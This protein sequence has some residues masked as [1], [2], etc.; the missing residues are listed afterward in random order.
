[1]YYAWTNAHGRPFCSTI[2]H[3]SPICLLYLGV[4][5]GLRWPWTCNGGHFLVMF[6]ENT[7]SW[8]MIIASSFLILM[9]CKRNVLMRYSFA[10]GDL[11]FK[12]E[13]S[14]QVWVYPHVLPWSGGHE[15][16]P[17]AGWPW[18]AKYF[19]LSR[20]WSHWWPS[21]YSRHLSAMKYTTMIWRSWVL[22]P[23][24]S[25]LWCVILLS[26]ST[27]IKCIHMLNTF[28]IIKNNGVHLLDTQCC[29][30]NYDCEIPINRDRMLMN[31]QKSI[32]MAWGRLR[33]WTNGQTLFMDIV[34]QSQ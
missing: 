6:N 17:H 27:W 33:P 24:G 34:F 25:N 2:L 7:I 21:G 13:Q 11:D 5:T 8:W 23:V 12:H 29:I 4:S 14:G 32:P 31:S 22:T 10:G 3:S 26:K 20:T 1:M 19:C 18:G 16:E 28:H 15:F 30:N 9:Q